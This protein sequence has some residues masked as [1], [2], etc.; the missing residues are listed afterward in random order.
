MSPRLASTAAILILLAGCSTQSPDDAAS[1]GRPSGPSSLEE[2]SS[3]AATD[4]E[5]TF[6]ASPPGGS[7]C[8][9]LGTEVI[10]TLLAG[11]PPSQ[12]NEQD[13]GGTRGCIFQG[14]G[15][16]AGSIALYCSPGQAEALLGNLKGMGGLD[17]IG[18]NPERYAGKSANTVGYAYLDDEIEQCLIEVRAHRTVQ[19]QQILAAALK[20]AYDNFIALKNSHLSARPR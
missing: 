3:T 14:S 18:D 9:F 4:K 17:R 12:Y 16:E 19:D 11:T 10:T 15:G 5:P 2:P 7:A 1:I 20:T 6:G 13:Q 8:A